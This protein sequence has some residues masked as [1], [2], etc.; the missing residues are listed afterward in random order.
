MHNDTV[1]RPAA[2]GLAKQS[3]PEL[4]E[5]FVAVTGLPLPSKAGP[6][7]LADNIRWYEQLHAVGRHPD[8]VRRSLINELDKV[9]RGPRPLYNPG[10]ILVREWQGE[11]HEVVVSEDG[12]RWREE[13]FTSLSAVAF[14]ITGTKWSGPRFFRLK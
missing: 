14:Q 2:D 6:R 10:T 5:R 8:R 7:F 1:N 9:C 3:L 12:Y 4:R 11:V 13:V